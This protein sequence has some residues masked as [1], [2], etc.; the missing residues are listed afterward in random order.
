MVT[1]VRTGSLSLDNSI[2]A[3]GF[4]LSVEGTAATVLQSKVTVGDRIYVEFDWSPEVLTNARFLACGEGWLVENGEPNT[5]N[6]AY[7]SFSTELH[8]RTVLAWNGTKYWMVTFDGRQPGYSIGVDFED[9]ADFLINTLGAKQA[10]NLDGGGSTAMVVNGSVVNEPSDFLGERS[11]VNAVM[12][13]R[14]S[15]ESAFPISDSFASSGRTLIWDDKFTYN[16]VIDF[17]PNPVP[18]GSDGYVLEVVNPAGGFDTVSAG[19]PGDSNYTV[20]ADIYC[21][22]R[23]DVSGNG[24]ERIGIFARDDG[25][26]NFD[27]NENGGGNCYAL[28]YNTNYG[29]VHAVII[30]DGFMTDLLSAPVYRTTDA[31]RT[32]RIECFEHSIRFLLDGEELTEIYDKT[33]TRGRAGIGYHE[34]FNTNGYMQATYAESFEMITLTTKVEDWQR[35]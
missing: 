24:F 2:P 3:N 7:Y 19:L 20:E 30:E 33:H 13:V 11:V 5:S 8:P 29:Q 10:I 27:S 14:R 6:W 4:V 1:A 9:M 35:Y 12:L 23:I 18:S 17:S 26:A 32:F 15:I 28:I 21:D 16:P 25:N 34:Y 31:W 22:Y